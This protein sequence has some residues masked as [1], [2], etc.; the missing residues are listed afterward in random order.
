MW[1]IWVKLGNIEEQ[2]GG[3]WRNL[4]EPGGTWSD[5]GEPWVAMVTLGTLQFQ[6]DHGL[7]DR[8]TDRQT[9]GH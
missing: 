2:P 9:D 3:T 6:I 7:T 4:K 8:Q 5:L 1:K